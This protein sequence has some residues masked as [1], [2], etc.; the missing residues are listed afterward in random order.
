MVRRGVVPGDDEYYSRPSTGGSVDTASGDRPSAMERFFEKTKLDHVF[1][2][3]RHIVERLFF[4]L[5]LLVACVYVGMAVTWI[6]WEA[7][8][9]DV[10]D[11]DYGLVE[12]GR[13]DFPRVHFFNLN[14]VRTSFL[15]RVGIAPESAEHA[16]FVR[17][18]YGG[19]K[20]SGKEPSAEYNSTVADVKKKLEDKSMLERSKFLAEASHGCGRDFLVKSKGKV[21][22]VNFVFHA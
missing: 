9:D 2:R 13:V 15:H 20:K 3:G 18:Y 4:A 16:A 6:V 10:V 22:K 17:E 14:Q 7:T 5:V 12:T 8:D 19:P 1:G 21:G 11:A